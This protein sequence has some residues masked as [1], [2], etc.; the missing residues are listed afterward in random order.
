MLMLVPLSLWLPMAARWGWRSASIRLVALLL[1]TW[2]AA[3]LWH[4]YPQHQDRVVGW[5]VAIAVV[6]AVARTPRRGRGGRGGVARGVLVRRGHGQPVV[7]RQGGGWV[8]GPRPFN[9][10]GPPTVVVVADRGQRAVRGV[11]GRVGRGHRRLEVVGGTAVR[12]VREGRVPWRRRPALG[13]LRV[14]AWLEGLW[15]TQREAERLRRNQR[16][17]DKLRDDVDGQP[18]MAG[19][20]APGERQPEW[21]EELEAWRREQDRRGG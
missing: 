20:W 21:L 12:N 8:V 4:A 3:S 11:A 6:V 14:G 10:G 9:A 2:Y 17:F 19:S 5:G 13:Y 7:P 16:Q 1:L 15:R 18:G